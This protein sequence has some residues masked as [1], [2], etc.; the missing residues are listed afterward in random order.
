MIFEHPGEVDVFMPILQMK[1]RS[2]RRVD[3]AQLVSDE[4]G[5]QS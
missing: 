2:L 3:G 1:K 5:T 4:T